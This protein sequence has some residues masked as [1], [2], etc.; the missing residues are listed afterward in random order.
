MA[1]TAGLYLGLISSIGSIIR[2][3]EVVL[4]Y[5]RDT[6]SANEEK[7]AMLLEIMSI[8]EKKS[9][10]TGMEKYPRIDAGAGWHFGPISSGS[11]GRR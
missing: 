11:E 7:T 1:D 3:S 5:I 6:A 8:S 4:W 10:S 2:F 9:E